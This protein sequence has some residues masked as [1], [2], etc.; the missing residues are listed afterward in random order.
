MFSLGS[1]PGVSNSDFAKKWSEACLGFVKMGHVPSITDS[2]IY[3]SVSVDCTW[4]QA[5]LYF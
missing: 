5:M 3:L 2:A 1:H 4:R